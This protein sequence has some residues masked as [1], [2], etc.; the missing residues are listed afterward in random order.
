MVKQRHYH[1]GVTKRDNNLLPNHILAK[2]FCSLT[3]C[4]TK[5]IVKAVSPRSVSSESDIIILFSSIPGTNNHI[6]VFV[7]DGAHDVRVPIAEE[8][9]H[10]TEFGVF[11]EVKGRIE[12]FPCL[13]AS[14]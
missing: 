10:R 6:K 3:I 9:S 12:I 5:S 13:L 4:Y 14:G 2:A 1:V 8:H 7:F 11:H